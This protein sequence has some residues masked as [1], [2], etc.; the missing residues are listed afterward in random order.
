MHLIGVHLIDVYL[1]GVPFIGV[2][3]MGV[4]FI[5]VPLMGVPLTSHTKFDLLVISGEIRLP[6]T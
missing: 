5:G 2:H 4:P 1:M 3:A 6:N